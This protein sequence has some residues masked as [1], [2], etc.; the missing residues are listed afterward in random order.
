M[1]RGHQ[2]FTR[3]VFGVLMPGSVQV[4]DNLRLSSDELHAVINALLRIFYL[5][6]N[7]FFTHRSTYAQTTS[8]PF[9][10]SRS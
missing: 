4:F 10:G 1:K 7:K 3:K 5:L 9:G 2:N 6:S 8:S